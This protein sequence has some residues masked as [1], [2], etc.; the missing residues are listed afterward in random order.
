MV[1]AAKGFAGNL[2]KILKYDPSGSLNAEL[3]AMGPAAG[4][5]AAKALLSSG[6]LKE[7]VGLRTS[8][9]N[10]GAQAGATQAVASV[11]TNTY[12]ININRSVIS[13]ADVIKE[14]KIY[15]KKH[16]KKYLVN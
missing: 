9:Y 15:E 5:I 7:I 2:A 11:N 4:N 12:E 1:Q 6:D 13:A 14:I 16:G 10:T 3:I 8:L